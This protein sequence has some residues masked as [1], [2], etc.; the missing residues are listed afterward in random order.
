MC[1]RKNRRDSE[2]F[3]MDNVVCTPH[4]AGVDLQSRDDM[5]L[6]IRN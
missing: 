3:H 6:A 4:A 5:A 2:L 1:S